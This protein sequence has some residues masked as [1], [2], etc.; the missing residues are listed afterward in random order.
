V[1]VCVCV[2]MCMCV[3]TVAHP[4]KVGDKGFHKD[5]FRCTDCRSP[6]GELFYTDSMGRYFCPNHPPRD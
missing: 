4:V 5:C 2:C 6:I 3:C 1:C